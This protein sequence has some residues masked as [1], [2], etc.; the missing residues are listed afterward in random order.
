MFDC[1]PEDEGKLIKFTLVNGE[2]HYGILTFFDKKP[3]L[4][5]EDGELWLFRGTGVFKVDHREEGFK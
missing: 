3:F 1:T 2:V 4:V 5:D